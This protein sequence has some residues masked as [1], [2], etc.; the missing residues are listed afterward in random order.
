MRINPKA[1]DGLVALAIHAL[2][3]QLE[4][5]YNWRGIASPSSPRIPELVLINKTTK[6]NRLVRSL[7][8][9]RGSDFRLI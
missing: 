4:R 2:R 3:V 8:Y 9:L 1:A 7:V 6:A 5:D